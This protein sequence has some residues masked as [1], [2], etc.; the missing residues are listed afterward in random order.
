MAQLLNCPK[1]LEMSVLPA[2]SVGL[3]TAMRVGCQPNQGPLSLA[4][5]SPYPRLSPPPTPFPKPFLTT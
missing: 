2:L 3:G 5:F 1:A 4:T